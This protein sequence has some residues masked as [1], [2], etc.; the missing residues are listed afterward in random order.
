MVC[1]SFPKGERCCKY[2]VG[3]QLMRYAVLREQN[4]KK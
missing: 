1:H 2:G 4:T 3:I